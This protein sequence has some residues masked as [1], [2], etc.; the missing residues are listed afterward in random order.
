[1]NPSGMGPT[2]MAGY[3]QLA[4][5]KSEPGL[6]LRPNRNRFRSAAN[7]ILG[8]G[9]SNTQSSSFARDASLGALVKYNPAGDHIMKDEGALAAR[10]YWGTTLLVLNFVKI[11][12]EVVIFCVNQQ[13]NGSQVC[14]F[15]FYIQL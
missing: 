14:N 6:R 5:S 15:L 13:S 11:S 8:G 2:R 12:F 10:G 7:E 9:S 4:I 3:G 1:M